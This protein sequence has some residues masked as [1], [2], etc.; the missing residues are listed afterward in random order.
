MLL[1]VF[2]KLKHEERFRKNRVFKQKMKGPLILCFMIYLLT[3]NGL[4][5]GGHGTV[6]IHAQKKKNTTQHY[7][8]Q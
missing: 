5:S 8:T 7:E 3:V 4:I 2:G 6:H 1:P